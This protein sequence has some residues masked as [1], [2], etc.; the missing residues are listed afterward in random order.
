MDDSGSRGEERR[1]TKY[2][3]LKK[4]HGPLQMEKNGDV[5]HIW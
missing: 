3:S 1:D 2:L 4:Y 5:K